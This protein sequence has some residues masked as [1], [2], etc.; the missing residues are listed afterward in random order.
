M[1][2]WHFL[3]LG[4]LR[5]PPSGPPLQGPDGAPQKPAPRSPRQLALETG[6]ASARLAFGPARLPRLLGWISAW[7][8]TGFRLDFDLA[9]FLDLIFD[10]ISIL[11]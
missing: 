9:G 8:S 6:L 2:L 1:V 10:L 5:D 3:P 4:P 7:I 11:I